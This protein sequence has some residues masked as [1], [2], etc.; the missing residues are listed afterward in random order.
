[1]ESYVRIFSTVLCLNVVFAYSQ[2]NEMFSFPDE[3]FRFGFSPE[4]YF[5]GKLMGKY[6]AW[7]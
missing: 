1:M 5:P 7:F 3:S 4:V 2:F 6:F